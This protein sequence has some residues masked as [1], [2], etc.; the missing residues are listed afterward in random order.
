MPQVHS[1]AWINIEQILQGFL[2]KL[3]QLPVAD[4]CWCSRNQ[5]NIVKQAIILQLKK[6]NLKH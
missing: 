4:S 5:H 6:K 3:K 1:S 2:K